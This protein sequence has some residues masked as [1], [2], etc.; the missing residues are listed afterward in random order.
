MSIIHVAN[1]VAIY[2]VLFFTQYNWA[3]SFTINFCN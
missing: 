3:T 1:Y 2:Y